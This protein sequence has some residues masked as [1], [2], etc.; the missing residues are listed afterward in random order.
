[1][2]NNFY[3][4]EWYNI[5]TDEVFYVGKGTGYRWKNL[6]GR[7]QYFTNYHNKYNCDVRK[8]KDN[9]EECDAFN[10]EIETIKHY[11]NINQCV[12]NLS[13]GGEGATFEEDGW[14]EMYRKVRN[15]YNLPNSRLEEMPFADY[16]YYENLK[17]KSLS[18][19][20]DMYYL[21]VFYKEG[22]KIEDELYEELKQS[23]L[24][25]KAFHRM[26]TSGL[27]DTCKFI[28]KETEIL[29]GL[30]MSRD[31]LY[32]GLD[33]PKEL[34]NFLC[35]KFEVDSFIESMFFNFHYACTFVESLWAAIWFLKHMGTPI[36]DSFDTPIPMIIKSF[37]IIDD[38]TL[39]IRLQPDKKSK[40]NTIKIDLYDLVWSLIVFPE[41]PIYESLLVEIS[42]MGLLTIV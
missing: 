24:N 28:N 30:I 10:L 4:Y 32:E 31:D 8:I 42:N 36:T 12:C 41:Q 18:E 3:V 40:V 2:R 33:S 35:S 23:N 6:G 38:R 37:S 34:D 25:F 27:L 19:L 39:R 5:D 17:S 14:D 22:L 7:N 26:S 1:M 13:E 20:S 16:Y 11:K 29:A 21:Y 9:L 15:L